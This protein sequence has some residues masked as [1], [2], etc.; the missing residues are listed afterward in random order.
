MRASPR[1]SKRSSEREAPDQ[2]YEVL[3]KTLA[4]LVGNGYPP[5]SLRAMA[6]EICAR[7]PRPRTA[8]DPTRAIFTAELGH[9]LTHWYTDPTH[10]D[11]HGNPRALPARGSSPCIAEL[12]RRASPSLDVD[13]AIRQLVKSRSLK[14][15]GNRYVPT[16][17][18]VL[19]NPKD[20]VATARGLL[21][22][23][24]FLDTFDFNLN[25]RGKLAPRF[26]VT[27]VNPAL[28]VEAIEAFK[29][30][31]GKRG[32]EFLHDIDSQMRRAELR[33]SSSAARARVGV[34]LFYFEDPG[35]QSGTRRR[36]R[37]GHRA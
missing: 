26:E 14:R 6:G 20:A 33:A 36:R 15:I 31:L 16:G 12:V 29:A 10:L 18:R 2:A 35:S 7:M 3:E 25:R 1:R 11:A 24:G 22:L 21:P 17:R 27:A 8:R 13:L 30:R 28:P 5:E 37:I 32:M 23:L 9:I 19:F 34:G 4:L